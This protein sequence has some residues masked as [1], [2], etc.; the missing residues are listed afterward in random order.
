MTM[1]HDLVLVRHGLSEGNVAIEA[2]KKGDNRYY[3]PAFRR[4]H[5]SSWRL[6]DIGRKQS[7]IAG[8]WIRKYIGEAFD[9]YFTSEFLRAMETAAYLG[10]PNAK[11]FCEF[12]IRERDWGEMDSITREER[13]TKFADAMQ[14]RERNKFYWPPPSGESMPQ[15]CLR[16][17]PLL[18]MLHQKCSD[19]KVIMV[20]HGEVMWAF[21]VRLEHMSQQHFQELDSS[22]DPKDMIHN[23]QI[24]Q[25]TRADPK[26][27]E[28]YD[29]F[30]WMRSVC[31]W[32][33][34]LSRNEWEI[35]SRPVYSNDDLLTIAKRTRRLIV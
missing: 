13:L 8:R 22:K 11:W 3:T 24:I 17:E 20:C 7:K 1:P 16:L 30:N 29:H 12:Y 27:G 6:V 5:N 10:L 34:S 19:H 14:R 25:Y 21:R 28:L 33:M 2:S 9:R 18:N 35:I 15:L 23:C 26:T 31:P 4:R 32:D